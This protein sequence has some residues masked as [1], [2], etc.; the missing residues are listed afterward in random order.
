MRKNIKFSLFLLVLGTAIIFYMQFSDNPATE[1]ITSSALGEGD[2]SWLETYVDNAEE[3]TKANVLREA[4]F[5][6]KVVEISEDEEKQSFVDATYTASC[7]VFAAD[8]L[9]SEGLNE[10]VKQVFL[11]SG[12]D[13]NDKAVMQDLVEKY[14]ND[15]DLDYAV[16]QAAD[17]C[18]CE[19]GEIFDIEKSRCFKRF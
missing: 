9:M 4:V 16:L 8:N 13:A 17:I 1:E 3:Q 14:E 5:E 6:D 2:F 19:D 12:F 10:K 11:D 15:E 7:L 18:S